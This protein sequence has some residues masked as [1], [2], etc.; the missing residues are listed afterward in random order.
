MFEKDYDEHEGYAWPHNIYSPGE[1]NLSQRGHQA[2]RLPN[3]QKI[4]RFGAHISPGGLSERAFSA[5]RALSFRVS[6]IGI[7]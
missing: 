4:R 7:R 5:R 3:A 2:L 6:Q 1:Q